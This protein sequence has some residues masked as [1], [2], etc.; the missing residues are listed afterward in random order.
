M[1]QE[2]QDV[3]NDEKLLVLQIFYNIWGVGDMMVCEFYKK[4]EF[5][6]VEVIQ[7]Y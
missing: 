1:L 2:V 5:L 6:Y 7:L 4:G 3:V